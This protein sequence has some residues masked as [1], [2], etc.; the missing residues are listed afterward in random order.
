Q[1]GL[2]EDDAALRI[3]QNDPAALG[4]LD[5]LVIV[6]GRIEAEEAEFE[7]VP[8][9][10]RAMAGALIAPGLCKDRH[11]FARKADQHISR[12]PLNADWNR[13]GLPARM[14]GDNRLACAKRANDPGAIHAGDSARTAAKPGFATQILV[15][16]I[17]VFTQHPESLLVAWP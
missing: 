16:A 6:E 11:H 8:A 14:D 12:R 7:A 13:S 17:G 10:L 15:S 5:D 1:R 9:M 2:E 3:G 4:A